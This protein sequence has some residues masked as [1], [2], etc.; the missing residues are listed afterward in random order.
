[1]KLIFFSLLM[2]FV[3]CNS[4]SINSVGG[5]VGNALIYNDT[6]IA[7]VQIQL[8]DA[9]T[10]EYELNNLIEDDTDVNEF[11]FN[12]QSNLNIALAERKIEVLPNDAS[13]ASFVLTIERISYV[14]SPN[15][16]T[17]KDDDNTETLVDTKDYSFEINAQ[18]TSLTS[19]KKQQIV[20][21]INDATHAGKTLFGTIGEKGSISREEMMSRG[22]ERFVG[23]LVKELNK[24]I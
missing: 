6:L 24:M 14:V 7:P 15:T 23:K 13:T 11:Q 10:I 8:I 9:S 18:I 1:M 16:D 20:V 21:N 22:I 3:V 12:V 2:F 17:F 4:C 5:N 19:G